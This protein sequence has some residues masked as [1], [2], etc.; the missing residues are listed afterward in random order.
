MELKKVKQLEDLC[1]QVYCLSQQISV[2]NTF[3]YGNNI[4]YE[5]VFDRTSACLMDHVK[6]D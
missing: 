1:E 3:F 6:V 5:K 4:L 2:L